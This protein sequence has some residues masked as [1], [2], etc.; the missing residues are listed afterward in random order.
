MRYVRSR[1]LVDSPRLL[2]LLLLL[3]LG[4]YYCIVAAQGA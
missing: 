1:R 3:L 2:R 4:C